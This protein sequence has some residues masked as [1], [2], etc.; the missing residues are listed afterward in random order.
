MDRC[1]K[2]VVA[3]RDDTCQSYLDLSDNSRLSHVAEARTLNRLVPASHQPSHIR[4]AGSSL[5][6]EGVQWGRQGPFA[7]NIWIKQLRND[8]DMF[9]YVLSVRNRTLTNVTDDS[10]FYPNQ[11]YC[12]LLPKSYPCGRCMLQRL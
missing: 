2:I 8:D 3:D 6:I 12:P 10:I 11:V 1:K 5:A 7:M 9:A 4:T